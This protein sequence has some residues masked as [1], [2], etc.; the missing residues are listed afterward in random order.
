[1]AAFERRLLG[2]E[3]RA[4]GRR[5]SGTVM[6]YGDT[7]PSHRER[8]EPRALRLAPAVPL[9]LMHN[10]LE[11][12]AWH[13]D[14]GLRLE[15]DDTALRMVADVPAIPAG[16]VALEMVRQ[17]EANGLSVEFR[18]ERERREGGRW[19]G[20]R[21]IEVAE[22]TGIGIVR[23]P[24]YGKSHVEAR[25]RSGR[26]MR[27]SIPTDTS[28]DCACVDGGCSRVQIL[29]E[30]MDQMWQETFTGATERIAT[31]YLENQSTPIASTS[32]G[33]LRG[34][35]TGVG[36]YEVEMDIPDSEAGRQL[37]A[38]WDASG[39]VVR[40]FVDQIQAEVID[41]VQHVSGGRLRAFVATSTDQ[42]EGWPD[43]ELMATPPDVL[44]GGTGKRAV[45]QSA[46][47]RR[48]WL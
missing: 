14:G 4:E 17:G 11:A 28:M 3:L 46:R 26:T 44:E 22:L 32:R 38:A 8:F 21:V 9:N 1:M 6:N 16:D 31:A 39:L 37:I 18:A 27:A 41:G 42:R 13:P 43:P 20:M 40:P 35:V 25:A 10:P 19:D 36:D 7:S 23:R 45:R 29:S 24:S 30:A 5:L 15:H 48:V 47:G 33:T 12:V 2:V 34:R